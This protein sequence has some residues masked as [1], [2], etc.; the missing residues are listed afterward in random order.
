MLFTHVTSQVLI[1]EAPVLNT[2]DIAQLLTPHKLPNELLEVSVCG[3]KAFL[4][5]RFDK[6][7]SSNQCSICICSN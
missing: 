5:D 1:T 2:V 3:R 4:I 6:H 7:S